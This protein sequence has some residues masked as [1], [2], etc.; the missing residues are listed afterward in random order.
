MRL[1]KG[2]WK[3]Q[4]STTFHSALWLHS[5]WHVFQVDPNTDAFLNIKRN[6]AFMKCKWTVV[7]VRVPLLFGFN[8]VYAEST[9]ANTA[10][11]KSLAATNRVPH[12]T[13]DRLAFGQFTVLTRYPVG[14]IGPILKLWT[15]H[16]ASWYRLYG[17]YLYSG[18]N[19]FESCLGP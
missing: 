15:L 19:T 3:L 16:R 11:P 5:I 12:V 18:S 7:T 17:L 6:G 13:T 4:I 9:V 1:P 8:N 2:T 14:H 10:I